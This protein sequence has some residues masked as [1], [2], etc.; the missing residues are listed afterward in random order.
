MEQK[1]TEQLPSNTAID[2]L[3]SALIALPGGLLRVTSART[4]QGLSDHGRAMRVKPT[5][6]IC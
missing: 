1:L 6:T 2:V 3:A 5:P 4:S